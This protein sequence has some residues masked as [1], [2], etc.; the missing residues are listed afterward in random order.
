MAS[1]SIGALVENKYQNRGLLKLVGD[2]LWEELSREGIAFTWGLP[3]QRAYAFHKIIWGYF[4]L[5]RFHN[6]TM[7]RSE[8]QACES[9]TTLSEIEAFDAEFDGLWTDCSGGYAIAVVRN[10]SYLNWRYIQRPDWSYIPFGCYEKDGLRGYVV[11]KLFQEAGLTRGHIV[12]IFGRPED[13]QTFQRLIDGSLSYFKERS[14]DEV[15]VW[16]WGSSIVESLLVEKGFKKTENHRPL[17]LRVNRT[18]EFATKVKDNSQWYF[19]MG[20]STEIF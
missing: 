10:S 1:H 18:Q 13:Q 20:D 15:T 19:T 5:I 6:W 11:L 8:I 14:V 4:D 12:D 3:N 9:S 7:M 17:V 2:K 16:I